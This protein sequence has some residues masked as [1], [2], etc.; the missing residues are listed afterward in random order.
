[1]RAQEEA[2]KEKQGSIEQVKTR[3]ATLRN[4][5]E[6]GTST[7]PSAE[8]K[9]EDWRK[10]LAEFEQ[11]LDSLNDKSLDEIKQTC[12][13]IERQIQ[14]IDDEFTKAQGLLPLHPANREPV[15]V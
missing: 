4:K 15:K 13:D 9:L 1:M 2:K 12:L 7:K 11:R 8:N 5:L 3:I 10:R 6:L 14:Q